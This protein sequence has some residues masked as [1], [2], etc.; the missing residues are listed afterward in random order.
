MCLKMVI[1]KN[2]EGRNVPF[3][4]FVCVKLLLPEYTMNGDM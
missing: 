3:W 1:F 2:N 4:V